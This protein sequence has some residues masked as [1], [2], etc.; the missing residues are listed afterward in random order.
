L[1]ALQKMKNCLRK[2]KM[3]LTKIATGLLTKH[4]DESQR[5]AV[6]AVVGVGWK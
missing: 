1:E 3:A 6:S 2:G 4:G 5:A